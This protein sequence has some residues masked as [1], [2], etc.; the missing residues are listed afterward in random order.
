MT[1]EAEDRTRPA[2]AVRLFQE[3]YACSQAV[4]AAFAPSLGLDAGTAARLAA[5]FA[6][7]MRLGE[8]C[9]AATGAFMVL[10]LALCGPECVVREQRAG[11][12]AKVAEFGARFRGRRGAVDCPDIIGCDLRTPEGARTAREEG[13]FDG[14]CAPAVRDACNLL[15]EMLSRH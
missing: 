9:G 13:R 10:G 12:C 4:L 8:A 11:I 5:P 3:G 7:G 15:E 2:E 14:R 6:A 1:S